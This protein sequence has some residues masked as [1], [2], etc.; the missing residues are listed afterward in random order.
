MWQVCMAFDW[1]NLLEWHFL[2]CEKKLRHFELVG[3]I[4]VKNNERPTYIIRRLGF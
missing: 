1:L 2:K 3:L 4:Q